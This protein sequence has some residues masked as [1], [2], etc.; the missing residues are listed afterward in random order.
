[1]WPRGCRLGDI[2]SVQD[3]TLAPGGL[4]KAL[5]RPQ[6]HRTQEWFQGRWGNCQSL[7]PAA[8]ALRAGVP[9]SSVSCG[10]GSGTSPGGGDWE[11]PK[12]DPGCSPAPPGP[13]P[14]PPGGS[15]PLSLSPQPV[16]H[17]GS[18]GYGSLGSNGSHEHL[19]SQTSSS[20][21]TGQE[22][23]CRRRVVR[24]LP[25]LGP[26]IPPSLRPSVP[27]V[28]PPLSP[29]PSPSV[30]S[31]S[32][33]PLSPSVLLSLCPPLS[34]CPPLSRSV[35]LSICCGTDVALHAAPPGP[36]LP[37][38]SVS[39]RCTPLPPRSGLCNLK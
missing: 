35:P 28:S 14:G 31:V 39:G 4:E 27:S 20:D 17:S 21:S 29:P 7:N 10:Q 32:L 5:P 9:G 36:G 26:P 25:P 15:R 6:G 3:A 1:M 19:M 23:P 11:P 13:H 30:P 8:R 16:P 37:D 12:P 2:P 33:P 22:D 18:S 24:P 34:C 38:L